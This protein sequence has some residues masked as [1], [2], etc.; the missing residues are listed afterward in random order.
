[1]LD[2]RTLDAVRARRAV[3][4]RLVFVL[5]LACA[6]ACASSQQENPHVVAPESPPTG[7]ED[8]VGI[9]RNVHQGVLELRQSGAFVLI[10]PITEPE[11]GTFQLTDDRLDVRAEKGCRVSPGT[12]RV[13]VSRS[14]RM[15]LT[16]GND[17]CAERKRV[18]ESDPW[19]YTPR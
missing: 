5:V 12:Y 10:S 16:D 8:V 1:V 3:M 19:I 11:S 14:R 18:M 9:W 15:D 17:P 13:R 7:I 6:S 2:D 4:K